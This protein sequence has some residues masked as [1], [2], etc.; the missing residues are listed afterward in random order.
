[1]SNEMLVELREK[2]APPPE[3]PRSKP[4]LCCCHGDGVVDDV[5]G[6]DDC[7]VGAV[8]CPAIRSGTCESQR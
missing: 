4:R 1:M 5:I 8:P 2:F 7:G 6:D 3:S